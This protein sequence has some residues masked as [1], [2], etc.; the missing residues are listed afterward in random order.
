MCSSFVSH[1]RSFL[2][3]LQLRLCLASVLAFVSE[4]RAE[5]RPSQLFG[6]QLLLDIGWTA[7]KYPEECLLVKV[8]YFA[9][10]RLHVCNVV[11]FRNSKFARVHCR[12]W[13]CVFKQGVDLCREQPA[14]VSLLLLSSCLLHTQAAYSWDVISMPSEAGSIPTTMAW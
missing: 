5:A 11:A 2:C 1:I 14:L 9:F 7:I 13:W 4:A 3:H 10:N 6:C 12:S 8:W